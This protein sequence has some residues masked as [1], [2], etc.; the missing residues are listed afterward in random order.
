MREMNLLPEEHFYLLEQKRKR[1]FIITLV[2]TILLIMAISYLVAYYIDYNIRKDIISTKARIEELEKIKE[3][4]LE[5]SANQSVL[6]SRR[7]MLERVESKRVDYYEL[8]TQLER[9]IPEEVTIETISHPKGDYFD[10]SAITKNPSK[11]ADFMVNIGKL[12]RV[13]NVLLDNIRYNTDKENNKTDTSF[14]IYFTYVAEEIVEDEGG[15]S[16]GID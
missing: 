15:D 3:M 6:D 4:Q 16:D 8:L 11:I 2:S 13:E 14:N 10:I 1:R 5:I 12:D 9:T 7:H